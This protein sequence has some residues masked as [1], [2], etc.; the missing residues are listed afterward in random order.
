MSLDWRS[1]ITKWDTGPMRSFQQFENTDISFQRHRFNWNHLLTSWS[2]LLVFTQPRI[3]VACNGGSGVHWVILQWNQPVN[4]VPS[5]RTL[6]QTA[7]PFFKPM[8][9][10]GSSFDFA[11]KVSPNSEHCS[12]TNKFDCHHACS[13]WNGALCFASICFEH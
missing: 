11:K 10:S 13:L 5:H 2:E 7:I 3:T 12:T 8:R 6:F 1:I 4:L 9:V